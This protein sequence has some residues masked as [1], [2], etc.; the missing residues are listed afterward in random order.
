[1][2]DIYRT[3]LMLALKSVCSC[4]RSY[5]KLHFGVFICMLELIMECLMYVYTA[6]YPVLIRVVFMVLIYQS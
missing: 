6:K 4:E 5:L 2:K 1:M 3:L